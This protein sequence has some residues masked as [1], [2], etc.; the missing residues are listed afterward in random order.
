[1]GAAVLD[2]NGPFALRWLLLLLLK[3]RCDGQGLP[4]REAGGAW[5]DHQRWP[6]WGLLGREGK[7]KAV[8]EQDLQTTQR[9]ERSKPN[10][11]LLFIAFCFFVWF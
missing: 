6:W 1:M 2:P 5:P 8:L 4:V 7:N 9:A 3:T 10:T 11:F